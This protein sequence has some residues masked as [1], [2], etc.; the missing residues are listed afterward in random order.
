MFILQLIQ[1]ATVND[2]TNVVIIQHLMLSQWSAVDP[3]HQQ[4]ELHLLAAV[5]KICGTVSNVQNSPSEH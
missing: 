1:Q 2:S 3:W 4:V 5:L